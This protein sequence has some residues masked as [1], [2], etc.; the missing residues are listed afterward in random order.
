MLGGALS[1]LR[2]VAWVLRISWATNPTLLTGLAVVVVLRSLVPAG[3]A[4]VARG[5]INTTV[6]K[7]GTGEGGIEP[8]LPLLLA[9]LALAIVEA[10]APIANKL[11]Q[12]RLADD[13]NVRVTTDILTHAASLDLACFED[14][15]RRETIDRAQQNVAANLARFLVELQTIGTEL[16]QTVLLVVLL[17]RVE[18]LVPLILGPLVLPYL[19]FKWRSARKRHTAVTSRSTERR[20]ARY[21]GQ[22]VTGLSSA[23]EIK[24]LG[25]ASLFIERFH[26]LVAGARE[27]ERKFHLRTAA[28]G[29]LFAALTALALY[30]IFARVILRAVG[31]ALTVGDVAVFAA[32]ASRLRFA[33]EHTIVAVS[34]ALE[35][36]YYAEDLRTYLGMKPVLRHQGTEVPVRSGGELVLEDV[37][38]TYPAT[39]RPALAGVSLR[40]RPGEII[41]LVGENGAGKT[42]LAKLLARLY[43]PDKGRILL[44]GIDLRD[45]STQELHRRLA[46]VAQDSVRFEATAAENIAYGDWR[47]LLS[48]RAAIEQVAFA[49][50]VHD[51]LAGLP[52]G[53]DTML[54]R[55]FGEH[56]LSGGQWQKLAVARAFAR[57]A[58]VLILDEPTA[59]LDG[60]A[61]REL[62]ARLARLARGRTTLLISHRASTLRLASRIVVM[63]L[64]R[65]EAVGTHDELLAQGGSYAQLFAGHNEPVALETV[66]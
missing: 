15:R 46:F 8:F 38:F 33:L 62:T 57:A 53:Y 50:G 40:V 37:W 35:Q 13:L 29:S 2:T 23:R 20:W 11:F 26:R 47:R 30:V 42:T 22:T 54:G 55:A 7:I 49:A 3:L 65:I 1:K 39:D 45:W 18:P 66:S 60:R 19:L 48:D 16:L 21:L 64:G 59:H 58:T 41:A 27:L 34:G 31:G 51:L 6:E 28:G 44:D 36:T 12:H 4:L 24:V 56:D 61:E 63:D 9:G 17:V 5:L 32:V 14:P 43:D 10:V 25:L 52:Q